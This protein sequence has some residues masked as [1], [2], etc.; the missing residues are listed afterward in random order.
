MAIIKKIGLVFLKKFNHSLK[1]II[2]YNNFS[3]FKLFLI[4][5]LIL[6]IFINFF[7]YTRNKE[8]VE[9]SL[10]H[11]IEIIKYDLLETFQQTTQ[12]L[13]YVGKQIS[14]GDY[15]N[16][17]FILNIIHDI[18]FD[19]YNK[20]I[21]AFS[22]S[23]LD[24]VNSEGFQIINQKQG[25]R[26]TPIDMTSR[27]YTSDC[28]KE[29]W[30]LH[31]SKPTF[32]FPSKVLVI[33]AG[34]GITNEINNFIG[35]LVVGFNISELNKTLKLKI[36]RKIDFQVVA[37]EDVILF[38]NN[39]NKLISLK[40][41]YYKFSYIENTPYTLFVFSK[42]NALFIKQITIFIFSIILSL[43]I[44][45]LFWWSFN[46]I[47]K[48]T[49]AISIKADLATKQLTL[50]INNRLIN[51]TNTIKRASKI[52]LQNL[53]IGLK[54]NISEDHQLSLILAIYD[55]AVNLWELSVDE[56]NLSYIDFNKLIEESL[57][58]KSKNILEK[59]LIIKLNLQ[60]D[61][62]NIYI[63]ELCTKLIII[64]FLAYTIDGMPQGGKIELL[65]SLRNSGR[66]K[67]IR[68][69]I[70]DY[71]FGISLEDRE[72]INSK[73]IKENQIDY[74][75]RPLKYLLKLAKIIDCT[76]SISPVINVGT[77]ISLE[78][79]IKHFYKNNKF[80]KKTNNTTNHSNVIK[81]K[82]K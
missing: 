77:N 56:N 37:K 6:V 76:C 9:E 71:G 24:W 47:K 40:Q 14:K 11:T 41:N 64:G 27:S 80:R 7:L 65:S 51:K 3:I 1:S 46:Y 60:R 81:F 22:W 29:P 58:I 35:I 73:L 4:I 25:L 18:K 12:F 13:T 42:K 69:D 72:R 78:F 26:E 5:Q 21:N 16:P 38:S 75:N 30:T 67:F 45:F 17:A 44:N 36:D 61:L 49:L 28:K 43:F 48:S 54:S 57:T 66:K 62:P 50:E 74:I 53:D 39:Y 20:I 32:G 82:P 10:K 33:P 68:V 59:G 34:V 8:K 31:F 2:S 55:A 70:K 19:N 52:L 15:N 63:D 23:F 79:P